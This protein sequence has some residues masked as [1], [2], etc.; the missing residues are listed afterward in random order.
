LENQQRSRRARFWL[1]VATVLYGA[2]LPFCVVGAMMSPMASDAG[3][4]DQVMV[5]IY[6]FFTWPLAIVL[7]VVAAW[8]FFWRRA[9]AAMTLALLF[10][11][12][13]LAP[14]VWSM[15]SDFGH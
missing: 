11:L 12:L 3:I 14:I 1:I 15:S 4:T 2:F 5:F 10:P 6:A 13:W 9:N 7:G 8:I